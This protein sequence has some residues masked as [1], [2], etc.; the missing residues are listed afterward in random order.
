MGIICK[1]NIGVKTQDEFYSIDKIVMGLAFNIQNTLGKFCDE[2]IYQEVLCR[3]CNENSIVAKRE[4]EIIVSYKEFC[5]KYKIDLLLED[6]AVYELKTVK[7]LNDLHKQQLINYLLLTG[8]R[9][10]KLINFQSNSVE[11]E[12]VS[13]TLTKNDRYN[14]NVDFD[15]FVELT[16]KCILLKDILINILQEWGA[17]LDYRLYNEA[18]I[19][20]LGGYED[21]VVPVE[22]FYNNEI[23]GKQKMQLLNKQ[24]IFHLSC[25]RKSVQSYENNICR[26]IK[27]TNIKNVQWINLNKNYITLKTIK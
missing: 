17:Y 22:F 15:D 11:Y 10:G 19:Y 27:H 14:F 25:V 24:T 9:H 3:K 23:V 26:L 12:F 8:I 21:V 5:K 20:F 4:V 1:E 7:T 16:D 6:G 18:I 13:T 2:K